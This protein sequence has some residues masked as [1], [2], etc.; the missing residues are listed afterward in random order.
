MILH[1]KYSRMKKHFFS[2]IIYI[3]YFSWIS[4]GVIKH[5]GIWDESTRG[6]GCFP[7]FCWIPQKRQVFFKCSALLP[8]LSSQRHLN[9]HI[10]DVG[11]VLWMQREFCWLRRI[12][13]QVWIRKILLK[14]VF[15][16]NLLFYSLHYYICLIKNTDF[17][18]FKLSCN[19]A[20]IYL[21]VNPIEYNG[22][23][24]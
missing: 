2:L 9:R 12:N 15:E 24:E 14:V 18:L 23:T 4:V 17:R 19:H 20:H 7:F 16:D 1:W 13:N 3:A 11:K 5:V 10:S 21:S 8:H 22:T 6:I